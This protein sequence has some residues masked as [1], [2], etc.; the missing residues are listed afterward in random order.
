MIDKKEEKSGKIKYL[1]GLRGVAAIIVVFCHLRN[2]CFIVEHESLYKSIGQ[3]PV[4]ILKSFFINAIERLVDGNL[5]VWIFWVLSAYV[6]SIRFFKP[7]QDYNK[8]LISS[9]SKRYFRLLIPV[10]VSVLFAWLLLQRGLLYHKQLAVVLGPRYSWLNNYY[11]FNANFPGALQSAFYETFFNFQAS[12]SYNYVLWSIQNEFLGS[13]FIFGLFG[14]IRHNANRYILY[15]IILVVLLLLQMHWLCA[16]VLGYILCDYDYSI[17]HHKYL[18][19][20]KRIEGKLHAYNFIILVVSLLFV[21]F[22]KTIMTL[23]GIPGT[24]QSL[25]LSVAIVYFCI[26]NQYYR[27]FFASKIPL[28]LGKVSFGVYLIHWP[29][30]CSLTSYMI[31]KNHNLEG[32][33]VAAAV[34]II[35]VLVGGHF[36]TKY[37]DRNGIVLSHRIGD[38]FK[39]AA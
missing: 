3:L 10:L 16:F 32:K 26:R 1:E 11:N 17:K 31:I 15:G 20:I 7:N 21:V 2:T 36:F 25:I 35:L 38:F 8:I 14:V 9:F 4:G 27:S 19:H 6:I 24:L 5:S 12:S 13:L 30:I 33:I 37:I 29:V 34:T 18:D 28:W 39:K 22:G 23:P